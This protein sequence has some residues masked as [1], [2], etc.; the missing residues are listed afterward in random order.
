MQSN[1]AMQ[2]AEYVA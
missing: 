1:I 2:F